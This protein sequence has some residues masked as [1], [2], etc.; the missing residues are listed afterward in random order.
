M[1]ARQYFAHDT[2]E[3][4]TPFDRMRAQGFHGCVLGE[5]LAEGQSSPEQLVRG[6]MASP[7]HCENILWP[8]FSQIGVGYA[9]EEGAAMGPFWVQN[10]G[11]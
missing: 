4:Q 3:Q 9:I 8:E 5:N 6:W 10:F 11:D 1:A 7:E 2:P